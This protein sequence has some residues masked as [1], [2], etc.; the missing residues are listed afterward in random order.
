M[1]ESI[2]RGDGFNVETVNQSREGRRYW[3]AIEV[4]PLCNERGE[5]TQFM[6]IESDITDR[7]QVEVELAEANRLLGDLIEHLSE[8]AVLE[9]T[10]NR[11]RLCNTAFCEL[12]DLGADPAALVGSDHRERMCMSIKDQAT[13]SDFLASRQRSIDLGKSVTE[14]NLLLGTSEF[15][16]DY[17]LLSVHSGG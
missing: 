11:V 16:S 3:L 6:A 8:A 15:L 2:R 10:E 9:D 14:H 1:R 17:V 12:F 13:Q 7:K 4:R 5:V